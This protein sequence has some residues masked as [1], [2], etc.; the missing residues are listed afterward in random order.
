MHPILDNYYNAIET[1]ITELEAKLSELEKMDKDEFETT[2]YER[3]FL[4]S[5]KIALQQTAN[6]LREYELQI[7]IESWLK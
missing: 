7:K 3:M 1:E 4:R 5:R 2:R 6:K